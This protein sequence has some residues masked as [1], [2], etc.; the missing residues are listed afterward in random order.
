M[1]GRARRATVRDACPC[2]DNKN[3]EHSRV[4]PPFLD[5]PSLRLSDFQIGSRVRARAP[6]AINPAQ[7][8]QSFLRNQGYSPSNLSPLKV[9]SALPEL[10]SL[11]HSCQPRFSITPS[12]FCHKA[13][14]H[15]GATPSRFWIVWPPNILFV[16]HVF[17]SWSCFALDKMSCAKQSR[18]VALTE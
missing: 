17:G 16:V 2:I 3:L 6:E 18:I 13:R 11:L 15:G 5:Q 10:H 12:P 9:T 4:F 7:C 1:I 14:R 8:E